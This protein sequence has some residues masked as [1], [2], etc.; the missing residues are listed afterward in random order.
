MFDFKTIKITEVKIIHLRIV[1]ESGVQW[2]SSG[3]QGGRF[4]NTES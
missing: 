4:S 1:D 2:T 3:L